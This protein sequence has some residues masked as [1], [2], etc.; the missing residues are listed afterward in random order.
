MDLKKPIILSGILILIVSL[1]CSLS[2]QT[3]QVIVVTSTP[4]FTNQLP[5]ADAPLPEPATAEPKPAIITP[6]SAPAAGLL[7]QPVYYLAEDSAGIDQVWKLDV[8]GKTTHQLTNAAVDISTYD[9]STKTGYLAFVSDND[10][11]VQATPGDAPLR[12][13]DE[14]PRDDNRNFWYAEFGI[15]NPLWSHDGTRLAFYHAGFYIFTPAD[16]SIKEI[17]KNDLTNNG[18]VMDL[19][20]Y[21]PVSWSPDDSHMVLSILYIEGGTQ[22][23]YSFADDSIKKLEKTTAADSAAEPPGARTVPNFTWPAFHT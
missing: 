14:Q 18:T 1:A 11:F 21:S 6:T 15:D 12:I 17:R 2:G 16:G 5:T 7:P 20:G 10:L 23:L 3:P 4:E 13:V 22:A 8:D 9:I 19:E